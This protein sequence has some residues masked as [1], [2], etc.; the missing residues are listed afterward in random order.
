LEEAQQIGA[1]AII[2]LMYLFRKEVTMEKDF[3]FYITYALAE[4]SGFTPEEAFT[5]AYSSQYVDDNNEQS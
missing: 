4:T 1:M 2:L 3:H 5:I